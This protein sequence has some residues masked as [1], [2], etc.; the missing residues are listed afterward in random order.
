MVLG[1]V[2]DNELTLASLP[3]TGY[4]G[5]TY[6]IARQFDT[7]TE[8]E[9]CI[10]GQGGSPPPAAPCFYFPAPTASL[11]AD[12]RREVGIAYDDEAVLPDFTDSLVI[13]GATTDATHNI[14]LT[15]APGNRH[16]GTAGTGVVIDPNANG[17]GIAVLVDH[18]RVEWFEVTGW[19]GGGNEGVRIQADNTS[20]H[21]MIV[22]DHDSPNQNGDGFHF[23]DNGDW[24]ATIQNSIVYNIERAGIFV[25]ENSP[26][27]RPG[28]QSSERLGLQLRLQQREQGRGGRYF[29]VRTR[30]RQR[31]GH[32]RERDRGGQRLRLLGLSLQGLHDCGSFPTGVRPRIGV[33]GAAVV[34]QPVFRRDRPRRIPPGGHGRDGVR[35]HP[36]GSDR[37]A[38]ERERIGSRQRQAPVPVCR[39]RHRRSAEARRRRL[40]H[41]GRR[42]RSH[43]GGGAPVLRSDPAGLCGRPR[44]AYGL[45]AGQPGLPPPPVIVEAGP[46]DADHTV[47]DPGTRVFTGGSV[48]LFPRRGPRE[49][50]GVLLLPRGHR[51]VLEVHVPRPCVGRPGAGVPSEDPEE[52]ETPDEGDSEDTSLPSE[53]QAYGNPEGASWRVVSRTARSLILEVTTPGFYATETEAG[54]HFSIPGFDEPS[55]PT[56]PAIPFL[57]AVVGARVGKAARVA[58]VRHEKTKTYAGL[59]PAAVGE[60]EMIVGW[61]GTVRPG[62]RPRQLRKSD[63]GMVP[64]LPVRIGGDG[65]IADEK[66]LALELSPLRFDTLNAEMRLSRRMRVKIVFDRASAQ[67]EVGSGSKGRRRPR[68]V[69]RRT[70]R[71]LAYLHTE[72]KGLYGVPFETL[73]PEGRRPIPVSSLK[74]TLQGEAVPFNIQ[75]RR[76]K[77]FR[78]GSML[79][80]YAASEAASTDY[81]SEVTYAL[82]LGSGG[83][84]MKVRSAA[85]NGRLPR[86]SASPI[87]RADFETNRWY[88][89]GLLQA[90]DLWL[91]GLRDRGDVQ[92]V[93]AGDRGSG[94]DLHRP[95]PAP[96]GSP[97]GLG[98]RGCGR[99]P[100]P[101]P[102]DQWHPRGRDGVRGQGGP[103]GH[104]EPPGVAAARG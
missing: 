98:R 28:T 99:R 44:M 62:R 24:T 87:A 86:V 58:W 1:V 73:F 14:T 78:P 92:V 57:R 25:L 47:A 15:V 20:Y 90:P 50:G 63:E 56:A 77:N 29:G 95:G 53:P 40:G 46:L 9:D 80:F 6:T 36:A 11:L 68:S 49:R 12:N 37:H 59:Y 67:R 8:W 42:V 31:Q 4:T 10:D 54:H 33:V 75:P 104:D 41:R 82:E 74:L 94:G 3:S 27:L 13:D 66:K 45:R 16:D 17:H 30:H 79:F 97:G 38:S 55:S 39:L 18:T 85:P 102:V 34:A 69:S 93:P 48:V 26:G 21:Y 89:A 5:G 91:W 43:D 76:K 60:G 101:E 83:V 84:R 19:Q 70:S 103:G 88:Q 35:E 2:S 100:P 22:H 51:R 71:V 23:K 32:R 72:E 52:G 65:F 64:E 81:S 96:R 7:L 61:D